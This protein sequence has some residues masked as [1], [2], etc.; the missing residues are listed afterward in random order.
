M[1]PQ[2]DK[3][4]ELPLTCVTS[5]SHE[6]SASSHGVGHPVELWSSSSIAGFPTFVVAKV[7]GFLVAL[8][9]TNP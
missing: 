4:K 7:L 5:D 3:N 6:M 9:S 2:P 1:D 8:C